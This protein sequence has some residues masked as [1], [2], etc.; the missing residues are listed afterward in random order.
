MANGRLPF[1]YTSDM[2]VNVTALVGVLVQSKSCSNFVVKY[3]EN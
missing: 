3:W 2:I 1:L